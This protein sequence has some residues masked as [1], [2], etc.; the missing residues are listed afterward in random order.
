MASS[1][2]IARHTSVNGLG[3]KAD[4]QGGKDKA[5]TAISSTV[6]R[7]SMGLNSLTYPLHYE[8]AR[9]RTDLES[10][11]HI[12]LTED[13]LSSGTGFEGIIG[14]SPVLRRLLQMVETVAGGD[15]TVLLLG[16]TA[17]RKE[18]TAPR[19]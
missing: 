12:D 17:P 3:E 14:K 9:P 4:R 10:T 1:L 13:T 18:H 2:R 19:P 16:D 8:D 11:L 6:R 5:V 15:S 7:M